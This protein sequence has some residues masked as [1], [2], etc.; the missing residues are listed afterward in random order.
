MTGISA[1]SPAPQPNQP[2]WN[3][4]CAEVRR[5]HD[6]SRANGRGRSV[7]VSARRIKL[8]RRYICGK[9]F[10][11]FPFV[12]HTTRTLFANR[13]GSRIFFGEGRCAKTPVR[14]APNI[15]CKQRPP[16]PILARPPMAALNHDAVMDH[17]TG[18]TNFFWRSP[19]ANSLI[20]HS[21]ICG[22]ALTNSTSDAL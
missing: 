14:M 13:G 19:S 1:N 8:E 2:S 12:V 18:R 6:Q 4:E 11:R 9:D 10:Q 20:I 7:C 22:K 15:V 5:Q 3:Q 17:S 21:G 16:D